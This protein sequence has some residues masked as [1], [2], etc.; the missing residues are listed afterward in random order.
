VLA[1]V[2]I[3]AAVTYA[4]T[5]DYGEGVGG[6]GTG[7]YSDARLK[8]DIRPA[9]L[10]PNGVK[11]YSFRYRNDARSFVGVL[12]QDLVADPRF[13]H[14]VTT[15][16]SGLYLVDLKA[17]GLDVQGD[18]EAFRAAGVAAAAGYGS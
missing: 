16:A 15:D 14:A 1:G 12:A 13:R 17:L 7:S 6:S 8:R 2:G 3:V 11:L 5:E 18:S 4:A 9:G 10:L